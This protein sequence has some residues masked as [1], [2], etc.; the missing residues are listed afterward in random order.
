MS[1][2][3]NKWR[4]TIDERRTQTEEQCV[5][6]ADQDLTVTA[7]RVFAVPTFVHLTCG[8]SLCLFS[9]LLAFIV[10][11]FLHYMPP[12]P[13]AN[14]NRALSSASYTSSCWL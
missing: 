7:C 14:Q 11:L 6:S 5:L 2:I 13:P 10:V 12:R 4:E 1:S 8:K 3:V 9:L